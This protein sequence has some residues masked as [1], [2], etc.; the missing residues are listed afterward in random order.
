MS[1]TDAD[2]PDD[3]ALALEYLSTALR[4]WLKLTESPLGEPDGLNIEFLVKSAERLLADVDTAV[5]LQRPPPPGGRRHAIDPT[6]EATC[7]C[8]WQSPNPASDRAPIAQHYLAILELG[9][10]L[11]GDR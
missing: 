4:A 8:G 3:V 10:E 9:A 7:L 2:W 1:I 5:V 6:E 11:G